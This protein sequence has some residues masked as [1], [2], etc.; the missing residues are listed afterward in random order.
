[1]SRVN[2]RPILPMAGRA[3][4]VSVDDVCDAWHL[5]Y[6]MG[7]ALESVRDSVNVDPMQRYAA[8][9]EA[10][11]RLDKELSLLRPTVCA[12]S[13]HP[14][15]TAPK[16]DRRD[17]GESPKEAPKKAEDAPKKA[18][19]ATGE[20]PASEKKEQKRPDSQPD[21]IEQLFRRLGPDVARID[22]DT[23]NRCTDILTKLMAEGK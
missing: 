8:L 2:I 12:I 5:S 21:P 1:M 6:N 3:V 4:V 11:E 14:V 18:E 10:R 19:G 13:A 15:S 16:A 20:D 9:L 22:A 23:I 17:P 7:K